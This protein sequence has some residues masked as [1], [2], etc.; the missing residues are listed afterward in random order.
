M[1]LAVT[2]KIGVIESG[3]QKEMASMASRSRSRNNQRRGIRRA[4]V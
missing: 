4:A 3:N 2:A 1:A